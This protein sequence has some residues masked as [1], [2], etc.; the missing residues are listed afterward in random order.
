[1]YG[2]YTCTQDQNIQVTALHRNGDVSSSISSNPTTPTPQPWHNPYHHVYKWNT[3]AGSHMRYG[4]GKQGQ[5]V[6]KRQRA[7]LPL[8][9][10]LN[11]RL[12][13]PLKVRSVPQPILEEYATVGGDGLQQPRAPH[14]SPQRTIRLPASELR[15]SAGIGSSHSLH[16]SVTVNSMGRVAF[17]HPL[18][19]SLAVDASLVVVVRPLAACHPATL[20]NIGGLAPKDTRAA[21]M[22]REV[23]ND[24]GRGGATEAR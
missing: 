3:A 22:S 12:S 11:C 14:H 20:A 8:R 2:L 18:P 9:P 17:E 7:T 19:A 1:M 6:H 5:T 15:C 21:G 16:K 13:N 10:K 24:S 23:C 4:F